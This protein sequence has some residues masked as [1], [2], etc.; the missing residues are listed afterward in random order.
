[1]SI[2][3]ALSIIL[4]FIL[5]PPTVMHEQHFE[6]HL[7]P[8]TNVVSAINAEEFNRDSVLTSQQNE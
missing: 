6:E 5:K 7:E 2:I 3:L 8:T 1:M 4:L